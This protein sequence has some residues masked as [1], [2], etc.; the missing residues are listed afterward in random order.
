MSGLGLFLT[1][2]GQDLKRVFNY[3]SEADQT[4]GAFVALAFVDPS[5]GLRVGGNVRSGASN[6]AKYRFHY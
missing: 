2:E 1:S 3:N 5:V 6:S 4:L